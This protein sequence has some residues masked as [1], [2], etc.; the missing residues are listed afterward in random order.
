MQW[1]PKEKERI[2]RL[3]AESRWWWHADT[4]PDEQV[5]ELCWFLAQTML[6]L[7]EACLV[8]NPA[9]VVEEMWQRMKEPQVGDVVLETTT[10]ASPDWPERALGI[11]R[12]RISTPPS[13]TSGS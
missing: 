9:P 4:W 11:L 12:K 7:Q 6:A 5:C 10:V 3:R 1:D 2:D 13:M 8:G